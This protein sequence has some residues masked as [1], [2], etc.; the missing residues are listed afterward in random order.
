M[1]VCLAGRA[2][3]KEGTALHSNRNFLLVRIHLNHLVLSLKLLIDDSDV[4]LVLE[5]FGDEN[6]TA[7]QSVQNLQNVAVVVDKRGRLPALRKE[8]V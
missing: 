6:Q 7:Q 5:S 2:K 8:R 3:R 1:G 4:Y